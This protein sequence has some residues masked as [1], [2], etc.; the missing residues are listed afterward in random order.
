MGIFSFWDDLKEFLHNPFVKIGQILWNATM[1][2]VAVLMGQDPATVAN[3]AAWTYML[4][5]IWPICMMIG[6]SLLT[7]LFL[8]S[9]IRQVSDLRN[10]MTLEIFMMQFIKLLLAIYLFTHM[11]DLIQTVLGMVVSIVGDNGLLV[12]PEVDIADDVKISLLMTVLD[13]AYLVIAAVCSFMILFAVYRRFLNLYLIIA[14]CPI[15]VST[16]AGDRGVTGTAIAWLKQFL[17]CAFEI[18]VIAFALGIG[19]AMLNNGFVAGFTSGIGL[20]DSI[21]SGFNAEIEGMFT[22]TIMT[23]TVKG[24]ESLLRKTMNL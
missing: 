13:I 15:A 18:V 2:Q 8:V 12:I 1:D 9:L 23:G 20:V 10:N 7:V 4:N 17:G 24:A 16:I 5:N 6:V 22:M 21:T 14:L 11:L 19:S 3:G